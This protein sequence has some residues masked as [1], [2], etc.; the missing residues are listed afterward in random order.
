MSPLLLALLAAAP[1]LDSGKLVSGGRERTYLIQRPSHDDG[2][3]R[4]LVLALHGRLG[5]GAAQEKLT[6]M[7]ALAERE[8]FVLVYP[9]GISRSWA[10]A[11]KVTPAFK[12]GVDDVAFLSELIDSLVKSERIDPHRV[13]VAGISNGGMMSHTLGCRLADKVAAVAPVAAPMPAALA[14]DCTPASPVAVLMIDGTEDPLVPYAGGSV[15]SDVGGEVVS[16]DASLAAWAK[17]NRCT[18]SLPNESL[19]DLDPKDGTTVTRMRRTGCAGGVEVVLDS[20]KGGGHTWPGGMQYLPER[21]VGRT[22]R[23]LDANQA[24][25]DFFKAHPRVAVKAAK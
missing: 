12:A 5:T 20:I 4:A 25:W 7:S 11:R 17:I 18:G 9:D 15:K 14:A 21:F 19:P 22:S 6:G 10:D 16:A 24:I 8:G 3:P 1:S 23:D 13:F 2:K